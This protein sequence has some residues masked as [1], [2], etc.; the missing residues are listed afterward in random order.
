MN[1]HAGWY[2]EQRAA[3][4]YRA[5][6]DAEVDLQ[7]AA[8]F[9]RLAGEA[10]ARAAIARAQSTARGHVPP[11]AYQPELRTR[12]VAL[13]VRRWGPRR[14]RTALGLMH[15]FSTS[16]GDSPS[17]DVF[18]RS[19]SQPAAGIGVRSRGYAPGREPEWAGFG[20]NDGL[21]ANASLM[22]GVAGA[23]PNP[24]VVLLAGVAGMFAGALARAAGDH[25]R[26]RS[27]REPARPYFGAAHRD[28][29]QQLPAA[30]SEPALMQASKSM[31]LRGV[32]RPSRPATA[33][34]PPGPR[35]PIRPPIG[36][37]P[38]RAGAPSRTTALRRCLAYALGAAV[39]VASALLLPSPAWWP[40][41]LAVCAAGLFAVGALSSTYTGRSALGSGAHALAVGT[42]VCGITFMAGCLAGAV[43][44]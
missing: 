17:T 4:L 44:G 21:V 28:S 36:Y 39:P 13:L 6:A 37:A 11:A 10:L 26:S 14:M 16:P 22:L 38:A 35:S 29:G 42:L 3:Y 32:Q 40:L 19:G 8:R 34:P 31:Q 33:T 5:C 7:R 20:I 23:N 2:R 41:A 43:L 24:Q 25:A 9:A 18:H 30:A 27:R 1:P 15:L 12:V